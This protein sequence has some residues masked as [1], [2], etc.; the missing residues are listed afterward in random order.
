MM[1]YTAGMYNIRRLEARSEALARTREGAQ[2]GAR[3]SVSARSGSCSFCAQTV[4]RATSAAGR[5][6]ATDRQCRWTWTT[7]TTNV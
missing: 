6:G 3:T 7:V 5:E 2:T 4:S 1:A